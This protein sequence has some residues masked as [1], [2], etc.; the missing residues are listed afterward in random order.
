MKWE[1]LWDRTYFNEY[2]SNKFGLQLNVCIKQLSYIID[3]LYLIYCI[4]CKNFSMSDF[5]SISCNGSILYST[6]E[7]LVPLNFTIPQII[8]PST[9]TGR[10]NLR[11]QDIYTEGPLPNNMSYS[12]IW[13][14]ITMKNNTYYQLNYSVSGVNMSNAQIFI[15]FYSGPNMSGDVIST[16]GSPS[17]AGNV[18]NLAV[19]FVFETPV[20]FNSSAIFLTYLSNPKATFYSYSFQI[21]YLKYEIQVYPVSKPFIINY[22]YINPTELI[23]DVHSRGNMTTMILYSATYNLSWVMTSGLSVYRSHAITLFS[24]LIFNFYLVKGNISHLWLNFTTQKAYSSQLIY[25]LSLLAAIS[26]VL[27]LLSA[28][29]FRRNKNEGG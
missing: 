23:V 6:N 27:V 10:N 13:E 2:Y 28:V 22:H 20:A 16:I 8:I 18:S 25:E 24:S 26:I 21:N 3:S 17:V 5:N 4:Y 15:R 12:N 29:D 14:Q 7:S 11:E 19:D 9:T 1:K